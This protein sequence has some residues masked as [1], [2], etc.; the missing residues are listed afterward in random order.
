MDQ[1][2]VE[3]ELARAAGAR[4]HRSVA[5]I[6]RNSLAAGFTDLIGEV[7]LVD[8]LREPRA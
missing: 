4:V 7:L 2:K 8:R 3:V 1:V 6:A 5:R